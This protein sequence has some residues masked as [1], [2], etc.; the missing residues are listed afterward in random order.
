M[1]AFDSAT[2]HASRPAS[3]ERDRAGRPSSA[4]GG[5]QAAPAP[6][7][8]GS[9]T[10]TP[11]RTVARLGALDML[12]LQGAAGN[13]A[14]AQLVALD[15]AT[16]GSAALP[17]LQRDP[18]GAATADD[19]TAGTATATGTG[20]A[21]AADPETRPELH[22]GDGPTADVGVLQ[23]KLNA[24]GA[25]TPPL[26][27]TAV[28]GPATAAAVISFQTN[29]SLTPSGVADAP[30]WSELDRLAPSVV[31]NGRIVVDAPGGANPLGTPQGATHPTIRRG[32][33]GP[34]VEELQQRLNNAPSTEVPTLL[35]VD[36]KFGPLTRQAVREFQAAHP[37]LVQDGVVGPATWALIDQVPG[38]V[39]VGRVEFSSDERVEGN[40]YGGDTRYTWR[41]TGDALEVT[42]NIRFTGLANHPQIAVWLGQIATVWNVFRFVDDSTPGRTLQLRL[43]ANRAT[44]GDNSVRVYSAAPGTPQFRSDSGDWNVLDP[45]QGLAPHEFGH[46]IG[47]QDE[48]RLGADVYAR[49]TG[50]EPL[51][52]EETG[53]AEPQVIADQLWTALNTSPASGRAAAARAV[54]TGHSLRQGAFSQRVAEA[55]EMT[56]A[57]QMQRED[58]VA[59]A[60][61]RVV[62]NPGGPIEMDIAARL[63]GQDDE[64]RITNP[65]T[66]TNRSLMGNMQSLNNPQAVGSVTSAHDHPVEE[67]HVRHFLEIL[68]ANRPGTWRLER[69]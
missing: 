43:I 12:Q 50:E 26:R 20:G 49:T 29:H 15:Q 34:A 59:G 42:V 63:P 7:V 69:R 6:S 16:A 35:E 8:P 28:Y 32:S 5:P 30:T 62:P 25:A 52:G 46:L 41:L 54:V 22:P 17:V 44:P 66:Y 2:R 45:D 37:P 14:V 55:Y 33:T 4:P 31:R 56:H 53:D 67:R 1:T 58:F 38:A 48:Y 36:G 61:Y 19:A 11:A 3:R 57:A 47:L 10:A 40:V 21:P 51:I 18:I 68:R 23:Q 64:A 13:A 27:I 9:P 39:D 65:F 24:T 60:G